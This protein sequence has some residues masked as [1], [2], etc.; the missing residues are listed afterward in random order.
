VCHTQTDHTT[1]GAFAAH[2]RSSLITNRLS[3]IAIAATLGCI[4]AADTDGGTS[5]RLAY[6]S[7]P[8]EGT[9]TVTDLDGATSDIDVKWGSSVRFSGAVYKD[10]SPKDTVSLLIGFGASYSSQSDAETKDS[11][12]STYG[13]VDGS[14]SEQYGVFIE[15]GIAIK[16]VPQFSIEAGIPIGLGYATYEESAIAGT[17]DG[18]PVPDN[19]SGAS[20]EYGVV[21]RPVLHLDKFQV[22]AEAGYRYIQTSVE[23]DDPSG[24]TIT[25]KPKRDF[26]TSGFSYS[27][28]AGLRF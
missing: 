1:C 16:L 19:F 8:T 5:L 27:I 26:T 20:L 12:A 10:F 7:L 6:T 24:V 4:A 15:P 14:K 18:K 22:F 28:G 25:N 2:T 9:A 3:L 11:G 21:V 17:V 13:R 23:L